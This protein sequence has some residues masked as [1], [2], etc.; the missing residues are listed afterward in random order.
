MSVVILKILLVG[1]GACAVFDLWQRIFQKITGI[2]PSDWAAV[3]RWCLGV[4]GRG[5]LIGYDLADMPTLPRELWVGWLV[6]YSVAVGYAVAYAVLM[7]TGVLDAG[8]VDG[9]L[10]GVTSVLVPWLFFLPC[11]GKGM[12]A[13]LTP[14]PPLVCSLALMMHSLF[15][16]SIGLGFAML[17][18]L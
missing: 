12:F 3:G 17:A 15:G 10:F 1:I 14:N 4:V 8:F 5:R 18:P 2:P 9:L 16:V 13:R 7:A 6:H 11:L